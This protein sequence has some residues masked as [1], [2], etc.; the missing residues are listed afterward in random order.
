MGLDVD[1]PNLTRRVSGGGGC[2]TLGAGTFK[3]VEL[4]KDMKPLRASTCLKSWKG[5]RE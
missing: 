5:M 2:V 1:G 4:G 3:S